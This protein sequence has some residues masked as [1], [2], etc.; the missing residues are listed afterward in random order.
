M[1]IS[2]KDLHL[3]AGRHDLVEGVSIQVSEGEIVSIIGPNGAGKT[4]LL[5][6][7]L[8]LIKPERGSIERRPGLRIGYLPQK[9]SIDTVLPLSVERMMTLT[10][11]FSRKEVEKALAETG[12]SSLIDEP[13]QT[14]SGGE[15]Q[16]MMLARALLRNPELLVLDEPAQGVDHLGEAELYGLIGRLREERGCGVLM[17]SHDLHVVMAATDRVLCLN[18]HLCCEGEPEEVTRHPEYL[19]LFG[20]EAGSRLAV[21]SHH[22]DHTHDLSGNVDTS[23]ASHQEQA[24]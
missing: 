2:A 12:V 15:F 8:G 18:R 7:L 11:A 3:K 23:H 1:L 14:L 5:K 19:R 21:Y 10:E 24:P 6:L 22:H 17:V 16:R 13:V 20:M 9:A 4:S